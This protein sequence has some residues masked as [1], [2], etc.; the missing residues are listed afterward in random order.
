[1][2]NL[3]TYAPKPP[4]PMTRLLRRD[5]VGSAAH[6]LRVALGVSEQAR[7]WA[8]NTIQHSLG[9]NLPSRRRSSST[10][11]VTQPFLFQLDPLKD[12][13]R[14]CILRNVVGD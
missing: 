3:T 8:P 7:N 13:S 14:R 1:M 4:K 6:N 9:R 12:V 5:L 10:L 2:I 11:S